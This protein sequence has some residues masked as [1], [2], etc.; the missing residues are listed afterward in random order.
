V[1]SPSPRSIPFDSAIWRV[2]IK[3]VASPTIPTSRQMDAFAMRPDEVVYVTLGQ[4]AS[5]RV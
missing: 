3:P 5:D 2:A 1:A 4:P